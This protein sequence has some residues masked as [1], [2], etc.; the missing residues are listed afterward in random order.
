M[1]DEEVDEEYIKSLNNDKRFELFQDE[2]IYAYQCLKKHGINLY[3]AT[4]GGAL[5]G[6]PRVNLDDI[7]NE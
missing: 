2:F 4:R 1:T 6:I 7:I 3:N 5:E